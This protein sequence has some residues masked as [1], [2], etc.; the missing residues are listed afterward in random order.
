VPRFF[1]DV[2][3]CDTFLLTGEDARHAAGSLRLRAGEAVTLCDG[4]GTDYDCVC[5]GVKAG[6]VLLKVIGSRPS[7]GEP[8]C[9]VV[10]FQC[11]P[12]GDKMDEIVQKSIELGTA[13]ISLCCRS[14]VY[15]GPTQYP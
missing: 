14:G 2:K 8:P 13:R 5:T 12:K 10:L 11:L 3:P 9:E 4:R 1:V 15:P 6:E 7:Q